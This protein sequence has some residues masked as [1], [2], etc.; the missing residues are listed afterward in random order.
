MWKDKIKNLFAHR[1]LPPSPDLWTRLEQQLAAET[2]KAAPVP[3]KK[4]R[5]YYYAAAAAILLAIGGYTLSKLQVTDVSQEIVFQQQN[6]NNVCK[7]NTPSPLPTNNQT[8][9]P[10]FNEPD[11]NVVK[12]KSQ[13]HIPPSAPIS[14]VATATPPI[15]SAESTTDPIPHNTNFSDENT[16]LVASLDASLLTEEELVEI[17]ATN[18]N[19]S[20]P[21]NAPVPPTQIT[22]L[23]AHLKKYLEEK[24]NKWLALSR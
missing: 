12:A 16:H 9:P 22:H 6:V 8:P 11:S 21:T 7:T 14:P 1:Q 10:N 3:T 23:K 20:Q 19:N 17:V 4:I 18:L 2:R 13:V 5:W 15:E 24:Y